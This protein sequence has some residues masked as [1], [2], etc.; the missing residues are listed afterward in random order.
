MTEL[1]VKIIFVA[2][3]MAV[4]L[5][6]SA[7][8][9]RE[10]SQGFYEDALQFYRADGVAEAVIQLRNALQEDPNNLAARILLGEALVRDGQPAAAI[11]EFQRALSRG[12]DEN[13]IFVPLANA[14]LDI[15]KPEQVITAITPVGHD[16]ETDGELHYLQG[17]AYLLM[18]NTKLADQSFISAISLNPKDVRPLIERARIALGERKREKAEKFVGQA[19]GISPD[20]FE[21]WMFK[22]LVHR[23]VGEYDPALAAFEQA[24]KIRPTSGR[25]LAARAAMWM[26]L[27]DADAALEDLTKARDL[28]ADT[29][30]TIY[31]RTLLLYREGKTEEAKELLV[32]SAAE[33]NSIADDYRS[34]LPQ[35]QMMLGIVAFF[36]ENYQSTIAYLE[37]FVKSVPGHLGAKRYLASAYIGL[38]EWDAVIKLYRPGASAEVPQDPMALSL[39]AEAY[40]AKRD[41]GRA[42]R[43]YESALRLAPNAAGLGIRLAMNRID[44]GESE[45]ALQDLTWLAENLPD[46]PEAKI[47]LARVYLLL[48]RADE[49]LEVAKIM[50]AEHADNAQALNTAGTVYLAAGDPLEARTMFMSARGVDPN[51]VLPKLNMARV[52]VIEG[53]VASAEADYRTILQAHPKNR[54]ALTELARLLIDQGGYDEAEEHVKAVIADA[55]DSFDAHILMLKILQG[56]R[57][58]VEKIQNVTYE[59][60]NK[61]PDEPRAEI[62]GARVSA[63]VGDRDDARLRLRRAVEKAEYDATV[64]LQIAEEQIGIA[65]NNGAL[66]SLTKALQGNPGLISAGALKARVLILLKEYDKSQIFLDELFEQHGAQASLHSVRGELRSVREDYVGATTDFQTAFDLIP[67]S[68]NMTMLFNAL[69]AND[70]VS[71][72]L[73]VMNSWVDRYPRD[74]ASKL[75]LGQTLLIRERYGEARKVYELLRADGMDNAMIL[76]NLAMIYQHLNDGR[77]L[78]V[79][80]LAFEQAPESANVLDTYGWILSE[81]GDAAEGLSVL[82][83]AYARSSTVPE[84]R[85]HIGLAL[86]KLGKI[87]EARVEIEASLQMAADFPGSARARTLLSELGGR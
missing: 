24:L 35:T 62:I 64:L 53:N 15:L 49:A 76:N 50:R 29:L 41:Y 2:A 11:E 8:V 86:V 3:I 22:A 43:Y 82:R 80:K 37:P 57:A 51:F 26:D 58:P 12:G 25:A 85:Y 74:T 9:D 48:Q 7:A 77:A 45:Q 1:N 79:A 20:S 32:E 87:E 68:Y 67:N 52:E 27:G 10:R 17:R 78:S 36:Q 19:L 66:W 71:D 31:L 83:E 54:T 84:I 63:T 61:F 40:R 34:M 38:K 28:E 16:S 21:I 13:L 30:E 47:Q 69:L 72:A 23:D 39:I 56:Q 73:A 14:Y 5:P 81:R 59:L 44:I 55:P 6:L 18:R 70:Q 60:A 33:I 75:L 42:Q 65:D 46:F 4:Q